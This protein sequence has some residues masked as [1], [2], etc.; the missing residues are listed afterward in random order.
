[1]TKN[2]RCFA[3]SLLVAT[4]VASV[5]DAALAKSEPSV[6]LADDRQSDPS[7]TP[8][9]DKPGIGKTTRDKGDPLSQPLPTTPLERQRLLANLYAYLATS[10]DEAQA[11]TVAHTIERLWAYSGSDTIALLMDRATRALNGGNT[12]LALRLLDAS[13]DLAPDYAEGWNRRAH[14]HALRNDFERAVGDLRRC[15]ALDPNH[16]KAL[17]VLGQILQQGGQKNAALKAYQRVLEINPNATYLKE[18]I[19]ILA[20]E[21]EGQKT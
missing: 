5:P 18:T 9:P 11:Q 7:S 12:D 4:T 21:V 15:L 2:V 20:T 6:S 16:Y 1:M 19:R 10:E 14:A 13:V 8:L 3:L 17:E